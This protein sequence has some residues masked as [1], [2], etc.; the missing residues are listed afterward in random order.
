MLQ[1]TDLQQMEDHEVAA[2]LRKAFEEHC[3]KAGPSVDA[4]TFKG[5][6]PYRAC[7]SQIPVIG[8]LS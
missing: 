3:A 2:A 7:G 1:R 8:R 6:Q 4:E 5:L